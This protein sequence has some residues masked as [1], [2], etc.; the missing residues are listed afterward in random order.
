ML[1]SGVPADPEVV[2]AAAVALVTGGGVLARRLG[3]PPAHIHSQQRMVPLLEA[4]S[5]VCEKANGEELA[6]RLIARRNDEDLSAH[7]W[8]ARSLLLI[9]PIYRKID[10]GMFERLELPDDGF[11]YRV[12]HVR[13]RDIRSYLRWARTLQ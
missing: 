2:G 3:A 8:F 12:L 1:W 7:E 9:V 10:T 4:A 13:K 6:I 11:E 5:M